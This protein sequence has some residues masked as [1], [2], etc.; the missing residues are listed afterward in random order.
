[1]NQLW[2]WMS[3][4]REEEKRFK[5]EYDNKVMYIIWRCNYNNINILFWEEGINLI[6]SYTIVRIL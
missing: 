2:K 4:G 3:R 5:D 6:V 1:M